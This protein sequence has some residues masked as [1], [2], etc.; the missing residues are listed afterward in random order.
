[1]YS[2]SKKKKKERKKHPY[3]FRNKLSHRNEMVPIIMDHCLFQFDTLKF[4]L[5]MLL[6]VGFLSDIIFFNVNLQIFQQN[7]KVH[8]SNYLETNF[9]TFLTLV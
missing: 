6:H 4:F 7:R 2:R 1:M 5:G 9:T 8:L 3:L